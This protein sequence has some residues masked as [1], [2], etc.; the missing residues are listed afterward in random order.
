MVMICYEYHDSLTLGTTNTQQFSPKAI[1]ALIV[2]LS[3]VL[4][5]TRKSECREKTNLYKTPHRR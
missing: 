4:W 2:G 5:L 1:L 3:G